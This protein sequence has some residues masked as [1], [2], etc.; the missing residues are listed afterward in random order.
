M[1]SPSSEER[2]T[3]CSLFCS[4]KPKKSS[5]SFRITITAKLKL[6]QK[7]LKLSF[8]GWFLSISLGIIKA[9]EGSSFFL[10]IGFA[11]HFCWFWPCARLWAWSAIICFY[12]K[13][14]F[15]SEKQKKAV[16]PLETACFAFFCEV[17]KQFDLLL[18]YLFECLSKRY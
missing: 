6:F 7:F 3:V 18:M 4:I 16:N 15:V 17:H 13:V 10:S 12:P 11:V 9:A 8:S 14:R 2:R 1:I 5:Q